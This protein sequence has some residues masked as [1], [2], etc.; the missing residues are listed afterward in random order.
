MSNAL[1]VLNPEQLTPDNI[2]QLRAENFLVCSPTDQVA[3]INPFF[4][5]RLTH[6]QVNTAVDKYGNALGTDIYK[7]SAGKYA[8]TKV[9]LSK[10]AAAAGIEWDIRETRRMDDRSNRFYCE[11]DAVGRIRMPSGEVKTF[12]DSAHEDAITVQ[13]EILSKYLDKVAKGETF[14]AGYGENKKN[15]PWTDE[16]ARD[17]AAK[18]FRQYHK[19]MT[20]RCLSRAMN[21]A[22]RQVLALNGTYTRDQLAKGFIVPQ[23]NFSPDYN[24]PANQDLIRAAMSG[25]LAQMFSPAGPAAEQP[26][27]TPMLAAPQVDATEGTPEAALTAADLEVAAEAVTTPATPAAV[28]VVAA[29][30]PRVISH[31]Y[32]QQI[33]RHCVR[34]WGMGP[35]NKTR[36]IGHLSG[37]IGRPIS[38][39]SEIST[40][41]LDP[42]MD[43]LE[44][45]RDG[46]HFQ[47]AGA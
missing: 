40:V 34:V 24:D 22:I 39:I 37:F 31:H 45:M 4:A 35:A 33:E 32:A 46:Q 42:V 13:E 12:K 29:D 18:E 23:V 6:V 30:A 43:M 8:P 28:E 10:I 15:Y 36:A 47:K 14:E 2:P 16:I 27:Q 1:V 9:L 20:E 5:V 41:E 44:D 3:Q 21:R 19:F 38:S 17:R 7:T 26:A 25:R 11:Y